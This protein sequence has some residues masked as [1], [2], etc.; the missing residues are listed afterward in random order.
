[1]APPPPPPATAPADLAAIV[2]RSQAVSRAVIHDLVQVPSLASAVA[3]AVQKDRDLPYQ[4]EAPPRRGSSPSLVS[5][6]G[7]EALEVACAEC[8]RAMLCNALLLRRYDFDPP[9]PA[10]RSAN[11][12]VV[13]AVD[14]FAE[15]GSAFREARRADTRTAMNGQTLSDAHLL[16]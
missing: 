11:S 1:M 6:S 8:R 5:T 9:L 12:C 10:Y 4:R 7:R 3:A 2:S 13:F 14:T 15:E 16:C